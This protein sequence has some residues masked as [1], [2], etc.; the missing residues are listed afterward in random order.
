MKIMVFSFGGGTHDVTTMEIEGETYK[1]LATSG[2]TLTG[3]ADIDNAVV[4]RLAN[5]FYNETG[6]NLR[7]SL[8]A[9]V[10]LKEAAEKA[11]IELSG[12]LT[13]EVGVPFLAEVGGVQKHLKYELTQAELEEIA[14]SIV[15]RVERT[16]RTVLIDSRL[17]A[18]DIDRLILIGGQTKMP[19]VRK[20]VEQ[21]MGKVAEEGVDP[22]QCVAIGA[23][24]QGA[25]LTGKLNY[26]LLDVTPLTLG[27]EDAAG[28]VQKIIYRNTPIPVSKSQSFTTAQDHQTEVSIHVVQGE[29]LMAADC[30]SI[31]RFDLEGFAPRPRGA[32]QILVGFEIDANGIMHVSAKELSSGVEQRV[33]ITGKM[34][35][36]EEERKR[37]I[38]ESKMFAGIDRARKEEALLTS[39]AGQLI[40]KAK[41]VQEE[42]YIPEERISRLNRVSADLKGVMELPLD[43]SEENH[44][45]ESLKAKMVELADLIND[46]IDVYEMGEGA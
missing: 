45:L 7:D 34:K 30:V 37:L 39:N 28:T 22:M 12:E 16:I 44:K 3:G 14:G 15:K 33:N 25:V 26:R 41:K 5:Q 19:L 42:L 36:S 27:I 2:D 23:A 29:R 1:V 8:P 31:G 18:E 17:G 24:Y 9:M 10:R 4:E 20:V 13:V 46:T 40:Y 11:K 6:V 35:I 21:F 38:E 43:Y 32:T